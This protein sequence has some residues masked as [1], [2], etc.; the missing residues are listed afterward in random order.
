MDRVAVDPNLWTR[1]ITCASG[2]PR[3]VQASLDKLALLMS[4]SGSVRHALSRLMLVTARSRS[5]VSDH[6]GSAQA[7][8]WLTCVQRGGYRSQGAQP[9]T[10]QATVPM[11]V[12]ER[13]AELLTMLAEQEPDQSELPTFPQGAVIADQ[14]GVGVSSRFS[15]A[16][17]NPSLIIEK[18]VDGST[19]RRSAG[20]AQAQGE[21]DPVIAAVIEELA[22][23][24]GCVV[25]PAWAAR[26][27]S[28]IMRHRSVRHPIAYVV[29]SLQ[30]AAQDGTLHER[31][32]PVESEQRTGTPG[33]GYKP[34]SVPEVQPSA[35][36]VD[37]LGEAPW[38]TVG[39]EPFAGQAASGVS[40]GLAPLPR[41]PA[42]CTG[43]AA[44]ADKTVFS[45]EP[46]Q[47]IYRPGGRILAGLGPTGALEL[48]KLR[49][50][51]AQR[52][53]DQSAAGGAIPGPGVL[54]A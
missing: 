51:F 17:I 52:R 27:V 21:T 19:T 41:I 5:T 2:L 46:P 16:K 48:V 9:S 42:S 25:S 54:A 22:A 8:G 31:F 33:T 50:Q 4:D 12:W 53:R 35:E 28:Q 30:N 47:E 7:D 43:S 32:M 23:H 13:R 26:C 45:E 49:E 10:Y 29:K 38:D 18:T 44:E 39:L 36:A 11:Q 24:T 37:L 3:T 1:L 20:S 34:S 40:E 6:L 15:A 14:G